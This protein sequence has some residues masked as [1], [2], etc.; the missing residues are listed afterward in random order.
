MMMD[1]PNCKVCVYEVCVHVCVCVCVF[2]TV[3]ITAIHHSTILLTQINIAFASLSCAVG[4]MEPSVT[5]SEFDEVIT[6]LV[7]GVLGGVNEVPITVTL[8]YISGTADGVYNM[9]HHTWSIYLI[10]VLHFRR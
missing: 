9:C 1:L 8:E 2:C 7:V 4:F 10:A 3:C 6:G 5:V